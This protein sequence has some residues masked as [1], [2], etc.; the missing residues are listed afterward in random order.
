MTNTEKTAD[1]RS[2]AH[3]TAAGGAKLLIEVGPVVAFVV[4]YNVANRMAPDA[5][6]FWATGVYMAAMVASVVYSWFTAKRIPPLLI[7]TSVIVMVF[8]G[9]AIGF[10]SKFFAYIKPTVINF[11]L[12]GLIVGSIVV[13]RNVWKI[14]FEAAFALPDRIWRV[15]A[16][17]WAA[18][19]VFLGLL[20]L[21]LWPPFWDARPDAFWLQM[22]G[23]TGEEF[24]TY[25]KLW[26]VIPLTFAFAMANVP[27]TMKHAG[28]TDADL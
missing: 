22:T 4:A 7:V 15:L 9:L 23:Q 1:T 21:A 25:F 8:G 28:K 16:L 6:I 5:A 2:G 17:R 12:A 13:G 3:Q 10:Q 24:W 18:W 19:F 27:I 11:L 20:N 26:G 14:F